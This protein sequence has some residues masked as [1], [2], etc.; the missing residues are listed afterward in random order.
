MKHSVQGKLGF[1][2]YC[3]V[4]SKEH[5]KCDHCEVLL[6]AREVKM[7]SREM[8]SG[9][10]GHTVPL[11]DEEIEKVAHIGVMAEDGEHCTQCYYSLPCRT[12]SPQ[13]QLVL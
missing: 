3:D 10:A 12:N 13:R 9:R 1:C 4:P 2:Q 5:K 11:T 6:H 8:R 7:A